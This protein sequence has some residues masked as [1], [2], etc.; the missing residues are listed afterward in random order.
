MVKP[1]NSMRSVVLAFALTWAALAEAQAP[2][3]QSFPLPVKVEG[4]CYVTSFGITIPVVTEPKTMAELTAPSAPPRDRVVQQVVAAL[5]N[6]DPEQYYSTKEGHRSEGDFAFQRGFYEKAAS[7]AVLREYLVG[8]Q[9]LFSVQLTVPELDVKPVFPVVVQEKEGAAYNAFEQIGHPILENLSSL[10]RFRFERPDEFQPIRPR[11]DVQRFYPVDEGLSLDGRR[12]GVS[13]FFVGSRPSWGS[14]V[15]TNNEF[16][17]ATPPKSLT[18]IDRVILA[19]RSTWEAFSRIPEEG[20]LGSPELREFLASFSET[21]ANALREVLAGFPEGFPFLDYKKVQYNMNQDIG[22]VIDA[23]P[24]F[25]LFSRK[26]SVYRTLR[27]T[28]ESSFEIVNVGYLANMHS[29]FT[30]HP[31]QDRIRELANQKAEAE[32]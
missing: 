23:D 9:H 22:Y 7:A 20:Y 6:N 11:E 17:P 26:G 4:E 12:D 25:Y 19:Y 18:A 8:D 13:F 29:L 28:G 5:L 1:A 16:V 31:F 10:E 15:F 2:S 27:R 21:S 30:Y 14:Q 24:V 32:E 3:S